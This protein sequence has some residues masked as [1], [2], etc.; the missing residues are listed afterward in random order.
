MTPQANPYLN[1]EVSNL[2][3]Y[4]S[5][6]QTCVLHLINYQ[7]ISIPPVPYPII[8]SRHE[9]LQ[10]PGH[11]SRN[12]TRHYFVNI[13]SSNRFRNFSERLNAT[14]MKTE[15][16]S[17]EYKL[18][19]TRQQR[20]WTC[21]ARFYIF[22]VVTW[23]P[24]YVAEEEFST[25]ID[26]NYNLNCFP[27]PGY[28]VLIIKPTINANDF[29]TKWNIFFNRLLRRNELLEIM[30]AKTEGVPMKVKITELLICCRF[31]TFVK[32]PNF[33]ALQL[34]EIVNFIQITNRNNYVV[35]IFV[36]HKMH[37]GPQAAHDVIKRTRLSD[38]SERSG[39][40]GTDLL[41]DIV[42][43]GL[44]N[45]GGIIYNHYGW[46]H[47]EVEWIREELYL[48]RDP[49]TKLSKTQFDRTDTVFPNVITTS[50][51]GYSFVTEV[52]KYSFTSCG[53]V[54]KKKNL[55]GF[56]S[57]AFDPTTWILLVTFNLIVGILLVARVKTGASILPKNFLPLLLTGFQ[58]QL[59][60]GVTSLSSENFKNIKMMALLFPFFMVTIVLKNAFKGD[61]VGNII[62]PPADK[63]FQ[64]FD[65]LYKG[66]Y[67]F[68]S[69]LITLQ[70]L[71]GGGVEG[72]SEF[73]YILNNRLGPSQTY[74]SE[75]AP[76]EYNEII[77]KISF[78]NKN[79]E[80]FIS[81]ENVLKLRRKDEEKC[82]KMAVMGWLNELYLIRKKLE[83]FYD[84]KKFSFS[85]GQQNI[86]TQL[87]GWK[88]SHVVDPSVQ[89]RV[90]DVAQF[91][92]LEKILW[93]QNR[94]EW[95]D[96]VRDAKGR[97]LTTGH[98]GVK[99]DTNMWSV[100]VCLFVF[101]GGILAVFLVVL[102]VQFI[103]RNLL[104]L[105][106]V[107]LV[108]SLGNKLLLG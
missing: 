91:G 10:P 87:Q 102:L 12:P 58:L 38:L 6:F 53:K 77:A 9:V 61:N 55:F 103:V 63:P 76:E 97:S 83:D 78:A 57:L 70:F 105:I 56:F 92:F 27:R 40:S 39:V 46:R 69:R 62:A 20:G 21:L 45:S 44:N 106:V 48:Y 18:R 51:F 65:E 8:L 34:E 100:I 85:L 107:Y 36:L 5:T 50:M 32:F 37:K 24:I 33:K 13:H 35:P 68:Y 84:A 15:T 14:Q 80:W 31:R 94:S 43:D 82:P 66:G 4:L 26:T 49:S 23:P 88:I 86:F 47:W 71:N 28:H 67:T 30:L 11:S 90:Q 75:I 89:K 96:L 2:P 64:K 42:T 52:K 98:A 95:F 59:E 79:L 7:T 19:I 104:P 93:Y 72:G 54:V 1:T 81:L 25:P 41:L 22:P 60:Q 17:R 73:G 108:S 16:T 74:V 99:L 29:I 3:L 101:Q